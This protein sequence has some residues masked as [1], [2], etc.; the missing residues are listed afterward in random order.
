MSALRGHFSRGE[1]CG[2]GSDR[3]NVF[4]RNISLI[5]YTAE[6][7][8]YASKLIKRRSLSNYT[9]KHRDYWD[10]MINIRMAIKTGSPLVT[11]FPILDV[12]ENAIRLGS[13]LEIH[14]RFVRICR[15]CRQKQS[16]NCRSSTDVH[17]NPDRLLR[18]HLES[19]HSVYCISCI[20]Q[21]LFC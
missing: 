13:N 2:L 12:G 8:N 17:L 6:H 14:C 4:K 11:D 15:N 9:A 19:A 18:N 16:E 10:K 21:V 5:H 1:K 7:R 20:F 3:R